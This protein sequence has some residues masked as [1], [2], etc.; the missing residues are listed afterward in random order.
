MYLISSNDRLQL[1]TMYCEST[2]AMYNCNADQHIAASSTVMD[3]WA[4][5]TPGILQLLS[6]SKVVSLSSF[7][8]GLSN[9]GTCIILTCN[10][11]KEK[12]SSSGH[13]NDHNC[14]SSCIS[15]SMVKTRKYI[16]DGMVKT[17]KCITEFKM[18]CTQNP[19]Q[20]DRMN[21]RALLF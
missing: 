3:F 10:T 4:R 14:Y 17:R 11:A 8:V 21:F 16:A 19:C 18:S 20:D 6:H 1:W 9:H 15:L 12:V 7:L 5:V 13:E 2:A